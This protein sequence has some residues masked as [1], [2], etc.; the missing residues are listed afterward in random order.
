M[1]ENLA[2]KNPKIDRTSVT[3]EVYTQ[4]GSRVDNWPLVSGRKHDGKDVHDTHDKF[5]MRIMHIL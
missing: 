3:Q 2:Q 5:I 1:N 4:N